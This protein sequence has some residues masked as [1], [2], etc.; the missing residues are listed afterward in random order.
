MKLQR[1]KDWFLV[2]A[3]IL[4]IGGPLGSAGLLLFIERPMLKEL[5]ATYLPYGQSGPGHFIEVG[6]FRYVRIV[7]TLAAIGV[8]IL[9]ALVGSFRIPDS[10]L[11][12]RKF[13]DAT[14]VVFI[15]GVAIFFGI[16]LI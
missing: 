3:L 6:I 10:A 8:G 16:M 1:R 2:I 7:A 13:R 12:S 4:F 9:L 14:W 5:Q 11:S 15:V